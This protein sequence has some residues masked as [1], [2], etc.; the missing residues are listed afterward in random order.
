[1]TLCP[2]C[3]QE[4]PDAKKRRTLAQNRRMF[5][6]L[7]TFKELGY[8]KHEAHEYCA[9]KFLQPRVVKWPDGRE[10]ILPGYTHTLTTEE[11]SE[12]MDA[13][14]QHLNEEGLWWPSTES[15]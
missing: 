9:R 12:Y 15:P 4:L 1:M 6:I 5:K 3:G 8:R 11:M 10:D 2:T 7:E 14:E 13:I